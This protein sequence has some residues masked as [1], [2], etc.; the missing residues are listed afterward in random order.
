M[1]NG[2]IIPTWIQ[3]IALLV[4][5]GIGITYDYTIGNNWMFWTSLGIFLLWATYFIYRIIFT[6]V[7][8]GKNE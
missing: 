5:V 1:K 7:K 6:K 4:M 2:L 8:G 3:I